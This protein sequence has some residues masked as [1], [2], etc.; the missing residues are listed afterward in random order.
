MR[1]LV[2]NKPSLSTAHAVYDVLVD[3]CGATSSLSERRAFVSQWPECR[4]Y[5]FMGSLGFGGKVWWNGGCVYVTCYPEHLTPERE[6]IIECANDRLA[7]IM[8]RSQ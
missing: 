8:E 1:W 4:E 3:G 5:R 6:V 7:R 2:N